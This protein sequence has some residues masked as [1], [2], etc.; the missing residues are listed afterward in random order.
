MQ[1]YQ[2]PRPANVWAELS[3]YR[4][5]FIFLNLTFL[6]WWILFK[7]ASL[8]WSLSYCYYKPRIVQFCKKWIP[9]L[10][11]NLGELAISMFF[12]KMG[13]PPP[14]FRHFGLFKQTSNFLNKSMWK[15]VMSV[16]FRYGAGIRSHDLLNMGRLTYYKTR[17][18]AQS[19]LL[20]FDDPSYWRWPKKRAC[21]GSWQKTSGAK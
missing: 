9:R 2:L 6:C 15:N 4:R 17:A 10:P 1:K 14:Q 18:P 3:S 5:I 20:M 11:G 13:Q 19:Y 7:K 16:Q 12:I 8:W 21:Q